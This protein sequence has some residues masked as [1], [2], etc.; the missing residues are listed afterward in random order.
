MSKHEIVIQWLK[1]ILAILFGSYFIVWS[2]EVLLL[3]TEIKNVII[4]LYG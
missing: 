1:I 2:S 3:L 4:N